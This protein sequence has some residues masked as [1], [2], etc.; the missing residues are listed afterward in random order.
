[1][2]VNASFHQQAINFASEDPVLKASIDRIRERFSTPYQ[3]Y[4]EHH[5]GVAPR[6]VLILGAGTGNDAYIAA[7]NGAEDITAVEIDPVI[8]KLG[9]EVN[10][11]R[12]YENPKVRVVN[13]DARHF[14]WNT[15]ES[16]DLIVFGTLD[17]QTLLS[18]YSNLRLENYVY[19]SESFA[20]ARRALADGGMMATYYSVFKPW[21]Y[22]RIY[23]TINKV[24]PDSIRLI[25]F[26]ENALFNTI[27]MGANGLAGFRSDP[28]ISDKFSSQIP[29]TDDWPYMYMEKPMVSPLYLEV[30]A[31]FFVCAAF[32]F[33]LLYR[34]TRK[35]SFKGN[36][37]LMGLGFTLLESAAIV[38]LTLLFGSTWIVTS[39]VF[40]SALLT[41]FAGNFLVMKRWAPPMVVAGVGL[42]AAL[43]AN[44][45]IPPSSLL[46]FDRLTRTLFAATMIGI[47]VLCTSIGFSRMF[48]SERMPGHA[49]GINLIGAMCGG[50]FEYLS[51]WLGMRSIWYVLMAVYATA[52]AWWWISQRLGKSRAR[53]Q[54][55]EAT[56]FGA[57]STS[58]KQ[59]S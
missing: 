22:G 3:I 24:F 36:F 30:F 15:A 55:E 7:A 59:V 21:F 47:P 6:K 48:A 49:L 28:S 12:P 23:A 40:S 31:V 5:H 9:R 34:Q 50:I 25:S 57:S 38:R 29:S 11:L 19:T 52:F 56:G 16:Y 44:A 43:A 39:V 2:Y 41:V 51:M 45:M 27:I 1:M 32:A 53:T 17:S 8:L 26:Q 37:F 4:R 10:D 46:A 20:D 35:I 42:I 54:V 13:D 33:F 58:V 14:L 18:G